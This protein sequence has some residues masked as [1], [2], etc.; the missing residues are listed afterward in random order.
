MTGLNLVGWIILVPILGSAVVFKEK[1]ST[2]ASATI[3]LI[4]VLALKPFLP[5]VSQFY[6][7]NLTWYFLVMVA[8]VYLLS[9]IYSLFYVEKRGVQ[10]RN[11]YYFLNLFAASMLFTLSVNNLGLMWVG[12][13][14]TTISSVLLVT[15]EGTSTALEAGWRY[16][17]LVS[18]GVT[19]AFI[20]VIL[21]YFGLH[22]LTISE[23]LYPHFSPLFSLASA[24]ALLG[25]GTK[26]GV[27]PVNTW[28]PDAHSEA[29]SPV[30]ALF[31]GVLLPVSIYILH[32][33]FII[34]PLPGLYSW[35]ATISILISS[36]M[37]ASQRYYK[38]LFAYSTIENM[39]FALLGVAVNSLTGLVIL[40]VTHAFAK[41]GAFY[42]SGSLLKSQ[43]TKEINEHGLYGSP[44]LASSLILSSLAV[45][46][47]PPFG[48]FIGEFLILSSVLKHGLVPQFWIVIISLIISFVCVNYHVSRMIFKGKPFR[49]RYKALS[50]IAII[51]ALISLIVG[52]VGVVLL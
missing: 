3:T 27:F 30:S 12:L 35:L 31:S 7:S 6:V 10:E 42:A 34:A 17:L 22:T 13:E 50:I 1:Y 43:G 52:V 29:P 4:L 14:A 8:G 9:S 23:V 19:F 37:M 11:Y 36:I 45:T 44:L 40:L 21:F 26:A 48:N 20:S 2:V 41:A 18:S 51:S 38:R 15:F 32:T 25:F 16:L 5:I 24:I 47:A 46:G 49:E 39:N 33:I 28:L